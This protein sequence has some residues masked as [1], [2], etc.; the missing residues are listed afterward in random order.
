ME[1]DIR[2]P[3]NG[4][5]ALIMALRIT[6]LAMRS[7]VI[8]RGETARMT[9]PTT[10]FFYVCSGDLSWAPREFARETVGPGTLVLEPSDKDYCLTG[11]RDGARLIMGEFRATYGMSTNL[12]NACKRPIVENFSDDEHMERILC[13]GLKEFRSR[14]PA[15]LAMTANLIQQMLVA[16]LRR[17]MTS[18]TCASNGF[19]I[20]DDRNIARAFAEMIYRPELPHTLISLASIARMSRANFQSK[21]TEAFGCAPMV[22]M[23]E[24][25]MALLVEQLEAGVTSTDQI[26]RSVGYGSG[27]S[28]IK[29]FR[30][31]YGYDP[32]TLRDSRQ[33]PAAPVEFQP[34][35]LAKTG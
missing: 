23:R 25:R 27:A 35:R 19:H 13:Q 9:E 32:L 28:L 18:G 16:V 3:A 15:S 17:L 8:D 7:L 29:S 30:K 20:L 33:R 21:F 11:G 10:Q 22:K 26:A 5:D 31:L 2:I 12:F 34:L 24:V 6:P 14:Q 4:L 1:R